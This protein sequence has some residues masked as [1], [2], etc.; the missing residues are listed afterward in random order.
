MTR[1]KKKIEKVVSGN[2][3]RHPSKSVP[4]NPYISLKQEVIGLFLLMPGGQLSGGARRKP[5]MV[6]N[7][8]G[9]GRPDREV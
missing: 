4:G 2:A 9:N 6:F 8:R 7:C 5:R 1:T 3:L